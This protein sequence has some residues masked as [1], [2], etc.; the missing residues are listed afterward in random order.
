[1]NPN[2]DKIR[3]AQAK[4]YEHLVKHGKVTPQIAESQPVS[5]S[6]QSII[7]DAIR[8]AKDD[9]AVAA[10]A[11]AALNMFNLIVLEEASRALCRPAG[12]LVGIQRLPLRHESVRLADGE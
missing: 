7:I 6:M 11:A 8:V 2:T 9:A 4:V 5:E 3:F 1:M 12:W 10:A